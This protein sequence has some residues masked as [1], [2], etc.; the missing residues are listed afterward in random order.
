[1]PMTDCM[2]KWVTWGGFLGS[3]IGYLLFLYSLASM[4]AATMAVFRTCSWYEAHQK[5]QSEID[6]PS[7]DAEN[8]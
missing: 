7:D 2:R 6:V 4:L 5:F 8:S 1:M 3:G